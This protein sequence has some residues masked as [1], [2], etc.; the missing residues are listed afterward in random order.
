MALSLGVKVA[1]FILHLIWQSLGRKQRQ[2]AY[3]QQV[4]VKSL[5]FYSS[6]L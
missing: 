2:E 6:L 5:L 4:I 1:G 3:N